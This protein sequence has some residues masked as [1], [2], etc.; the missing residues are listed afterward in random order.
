MPTS[1][2]PSSARPLFF[3]PV[4]LC[5]GNAVVVCE[6]QVRAR[7]EGNPGKGKKK[8]QGLEEEVDQ[9]APPPLPR[10]FFPL[11]PLVLS[12]RPLSPSAA[13][14]VP[15]ACPPRPAAPRG[16]FPPCSRPS[17]FPPVRLPR[18]RSGREESRVSRLEPSRCPLPSVLGAP[19]RRST[20]VCAG[21]RLVRMEIT[22]GSGLGPG[23]SPFKALTKTQRAT[24]DGGPKPQ[25]QH[26]RERTESG[27]STGNVLYKILNRRR[28][29]WGCCI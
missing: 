15:P 5:L 29:H 3:F 14:S 7:G 17:S 11:R 2:P 6:G 22:R 12:F 8:R 23:G 10:R 16:P 21:T 19:I 20:R 24:P 4:R 13:L 26:R 25:E 28:R 9:R 18:G 27:I 1:A